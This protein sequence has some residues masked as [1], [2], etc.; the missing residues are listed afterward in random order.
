VDANSL[1]GIHKVRVAPATRSAVATCKSI[2]IEYTVH[3]QKP[4]NTTRPPK[5]VVNKYFGGKSVGKRVV[6]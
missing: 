2:S 4:G 1:P 3:L 5:P 6:T